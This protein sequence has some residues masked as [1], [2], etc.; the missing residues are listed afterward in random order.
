MRVFYWVAALHK[1]PCF[2]NHLAKTIIGDPLYGFKN[3]HLI[4]MNLM[5]GNMENISHALIFTWP[6]MTSSLTS[7]GS[8]KDITQ[9]FSLSSFLVLS[10]DTK[11]AHLRRRWK[12]LRANQCYANLPYVSINLYFREAVP[13]KTFPWIFPH[14][15][16]IKNT[17]TF[18]VSNGVNVRF[19]H[20]VF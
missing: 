4:R 6:D 9:H 8:V 17:S 10:F 11:M 19:V 5:H 20:R 16:F 12:I 3:K 13:L 7:H 18:D 14:P 15:N 1:A 2:Y